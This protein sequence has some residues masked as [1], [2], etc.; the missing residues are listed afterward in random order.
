MRYKVQRTEKLLTYFHFLM[1]IP[2]INNQVI[3]SD[4]STL[5]G[6]VKLKSN[7]F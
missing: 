7:D 1:H 3:R 5:L 2:C 4:A 6:Q